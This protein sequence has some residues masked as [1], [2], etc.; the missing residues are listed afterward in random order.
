MSITYEYL[1]PYNCILEVAVVQW[2]SSLEM[3]MVT[4]IQI[5]DEVFLPPVMG[6]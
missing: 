6:K 4:Q 5:L 2:L 3:D 1:K